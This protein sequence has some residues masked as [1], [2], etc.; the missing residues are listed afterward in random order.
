MSL[1]YFDESRF[2]RQVD[3]ALQRIR[4]VL[5]ITRAPQYPADVPHAYDDKYGLAEFLTN[6]AIAAELNVLDLLGV[7]DKHLSTMRKWVQS[8]SVTL[9][10][11]SEERCSFIKETTREVESA[12][13]YVTEYSDNANN[14]ASV[15]RKVVTTITE[16]F[17]KFTVDY[18]L[19]AFQGAQLSLFVWLFALFV[20]GTRLHFSCCCF[21]LFPPSPSL[22]LSHNSLP[23]PLSSFSFS[24]LLFLGCTYRQRR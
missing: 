23:L 10:L 14:T 8:R 17:W 11:K 20:V 13:K 16:Y 2:R 5:D 1:Q 21:A 15:T 24:F 7:T 9:R 6:T 19:F 3:S 12:T 22:P 18:E 4:T